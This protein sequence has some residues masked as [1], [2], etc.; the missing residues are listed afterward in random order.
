VAEAGENRAFTHAGFYS[1]IPVPIWAY[2]L[3]IDVILD[4]ALTQTT[5]TGHSRLRPA[6]EQL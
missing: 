6:A 4:V 5:P 2:F 1:H 3:L